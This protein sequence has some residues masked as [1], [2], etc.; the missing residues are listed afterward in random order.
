MSARKIFV[1]SLPPNITDGQLR[2]EFE[3]HG[4]IE[5][6]FVKPG[7]EVG[8]QWAFLTFATAE[9]AQRAKN[10]CDRVLTFPG[11][12]RACDVML[13]KNQGMGGQ[14]AA[15]TPQ[16]PAGSS[17]ATYVGQQDLGT[18]PRKI[19]VGSL[20]NDIQDAQLHTEFSK[21]GTVEDVYIK[22]GCEPGRQWAFVTLATGAQ[23][24]AAKAASDGVLTFP[25]STRACEVTLARHQGM[26]GQEPLTS[27]P[28]QP[29]G[30]ATAAAD[31][32]QAHAA[33]IQAAYA[34]QAYYAAGGYTA[35]A[36][37]VYAGQYAA[38]AQAAAYAAAPVA[39][40]A[41]AGPADS[42]APKKIFVG[43]LPDNISDS[44]LRGEFQK[45]GQIVDVFLKTG[46]EPGRQWAFVTYAT[47]EQAQNAKATC[48]RK[49][50]LPGA[51][52]PCE[53]M[54]SRNQGKNGE[55][56]MSNTTVAT[57][58][59]SFP[60]Y[61]ANP[62]AQGDA[63]AGGLSAAAAY[64]PYMYPGAHGVPCGALGV[65]PPPPAA[66]PPAHLTSWRMYYTAAGLPY[67]HNATTG[68]TQWECP[69]DFQVPGQGLLAAIP[70]AAPGPMPV[71]AAPAAGMYAA[72]V[73]PQMAPGMAR[74]APY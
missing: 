74:Y 27:P 9:E 6:V 24:Q 29:Q 26:F 71:M 62:P 53:V 31:A 25:G 32:A 49:L 1:G 64:A 63:A 55:L 34:G 14:P 23:A 33:A 11:A 43:S 7:C 73:Q 13:A 50:I 48:D 41:A 69:P 4:H 3:K 45:F 8:R 22:Q 30:A 15:P 46:C 58:V 12:E 42:V 36:G 44:V 54:F 38:A 20:P 56:P 2:A 47:H 51:D 70:A 52:R 37:A 72:M 68:V 61:G 28:A 67:Y 65:Q 16:S 39:A 10:A 59:N 17:A 60:F 21:Y 19:F 18:E 40:V 35:A 57:G 66:P 5:D